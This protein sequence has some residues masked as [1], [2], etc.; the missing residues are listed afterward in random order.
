MKLPDKTPIIEYTHSLRSRY[1]ETD[2]MGYVYYGRYLEYF[3]VA[4]T[5]MIRSHGL[6]YRELEESGVM[7]PVI[8]SEIEYK[9][10][11]LYD[12][13][14]FV[15]VMVFD[16]PAVRLQTFYEVTTPD[17]DSIHVYGEV[18]LCFMDAESRKPCRAPKSFIDGMQNKLKA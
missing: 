14:M 13:E 10:P 17:S 5:E 4:R 8:H 1:G 12:E 15:K 9:A 16:V 11:I 6:S 7:L 2:R 18:S 3:E